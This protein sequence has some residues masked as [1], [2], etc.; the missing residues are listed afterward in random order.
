VGLA[1]LASGARPG[2]RLVSVE[3][4]TERAGLVADL[5]ANLPHLAVLPGDWREIYRTAPDL[6]ALVA[7]RR[8][9]AS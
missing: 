7:T 8:F 3:I 2:T 9:P 4:D 6:A 5:F 1:W